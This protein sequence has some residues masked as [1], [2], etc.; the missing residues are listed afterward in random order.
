MIGSSGGH[1]GNNPYRGEYYHFGLLTADDDGLHLA[2]IP[3]AEIRSENWLTMDDRVIQ[4][5]L[6][7][8]LLSI[9]KPVMKEGGKTSVRLVMAPDCGAG[10]G[11]YRWNCDGT[12]WF[13]SP[14]SGTFDLNDGPKTVDC[15]A[16]VRGGLYPVPTLEV[17][18][19]PGDREYKMFRV[20]EPTFRQTVPDGSQ[21]PVIDGRPDEAVWDDCL[22]IDDFGDQDGG[23]CPTD[24]VEVRLVHD[25]ERLYI[26]IKA[27]GKAEGKADTGKANTEIPSRDG[28]V[29]MKDC[30]YLVFWSDETPS[31]ITQFV[32]NAEGGLLDQQGLAPA[33][34][35]DRPDMDQKWNADVEAEGC[36]RGDAVGGGNGDP[37]AGCGANLSGNISL[38]CAAVSAGERWIILV[39]R[40][41]N[42]Q[43]AGCGVVEA[44]AA[45][46]GEVMV[47]YTAQR[48][49]FE[50]GLG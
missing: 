31:R 14:L 17:T 15:A 30:I 1:I 3:A 27:E 48:V 38:Q 12:A 44:G 22:I 7:D 29:F 41:G 6:E 19:A 28:P 2:V 10:A 23:A 16:L 11:S 43:R 49:V 21:A 32:V 26:S 45:A 50:F 39:D 25:A 9:S 13:V 37:A 4:D 34:E 8:C 33:D 35:E 47:R 20:L 24:P 5:K 18:T 40:P 42:I 46:G 36:W